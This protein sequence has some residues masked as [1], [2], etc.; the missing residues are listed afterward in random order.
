M[1]TV[2][3]GREIFVVNQYVK[4]TYKQTNKKTN[5]TTHLKKKKKSLPQS[6]SV[7]AKQLLAA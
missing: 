1:H 6:I 4:K 3:M 2:L 5:K 7:C